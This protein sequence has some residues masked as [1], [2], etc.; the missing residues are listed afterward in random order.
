LNLIRERPSSDIQRN[1]LTGHSCMK[2]HAV[3]SR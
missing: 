2:Y 1:D 3:L